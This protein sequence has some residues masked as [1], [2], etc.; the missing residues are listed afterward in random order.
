MKKSLVKDMPR[1]LS[2]PA[3]YCPF[4]IQSY[5]LEKAL[6]LA[7]AEAIDDGD[8]AFLENRWLKVEVSDLSASW[9]ITFEAQQL[10]VKSVVEHADVSFSG[11]LNEFVL[12]M[13]RQE[14]PDTLFFQRRLRVEGDT[15]LGL[16]LKNLLDNLD[17]DNL[18]DW[19][20]D[21]LQKSAGLVAKYQAA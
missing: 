19:L 2:I 8:L 15:E 11:N 4:A 7:F 10:K 18:P 20:S 12:L 14:D 6:K 5:A 1:I 3:R 13:G 21:S 9:F 17:F 16:E